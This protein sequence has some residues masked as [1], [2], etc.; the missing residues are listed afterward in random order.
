MLWLVWYLHFNVMIVISI[1]ISAFLTSSWVISSPFALFPNIFLDSC[2]CFQF[3]PLLHGFHWWLVWC[4]DFSQIN[5]FFFQLIFQGYLD[6]YSMLIGWRRLLRFPICYGSLSL[7]L[8]FLF[9]FFVLTEEWRSRGYWMQLNFLVQGENVGHSMYI[10]YLWLQIFGMS[11]TSH[12]GFSDS[13]TK[14]HWIILR[15]RLA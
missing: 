2:Q 10:L 3:D 13:V 11:W 9:I 14:S 6:F 15:T 8:P 7:S 1:G 5:F 12:V 4:L